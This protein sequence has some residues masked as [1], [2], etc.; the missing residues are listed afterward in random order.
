MQDHAKQGAELQEAFPQPTS[1]SST[2]MLKTVLKVAFAGALIYWLIHKGALDLDSFR[3]IASPQLI[4]VCMSCMF[5]QLFF[6]NYRWLLLLRGQGI[7]S[8]VRYT[9]PL[10][11]IGLFFNFVMPGGVGGDVIKGYYL[12]QDQ[13]QRRLAA[14]ISILVDRLVGFFIMVGTAFF[15]LFL[16]W[17]SVSHSGELTSI[18]ISVTVLFTAFVAFFALALSRRLGRMVFSA[19]F[20]HFLF[21]QMPGGEKLRRIYDLVHSYRNH[22]GVLLKAGILSALTQIPNVG[23]F[24]FV[25]LAMGVHEIPLAVYFFL[26]PVGTV[27]LALPISPAGIG[28]GQAAFFFL[29]SLYLGKSSQ[30]GATAV[31]LMQVMSFAW[32]LLG[33]YFYLLRKKPAAMTTA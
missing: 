17:D 3:K 20:G 26:V 28:V 30:L 33:A 32:G 11:F 12:L 14:A 2:E 15:A 22:P 6:N 21:V 8:S 4:A 25:G 16:N 18:A 5:L 7:N 24:Y 13:P 27:V 9:F 1:K 29:F 10:T 19:R 31:T 23:L